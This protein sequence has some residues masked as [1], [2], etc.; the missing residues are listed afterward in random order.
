MIHNTSFIKDL[1]RKSRDTLLQL[2]ITNFWI[3]FLLL[4]DNLK[5]M[6]FIDYV[7]ITEQALAEEYLLARHV[8]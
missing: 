4:M 2:G 5:A 1:S 3:V 8:L 7:F 6:T